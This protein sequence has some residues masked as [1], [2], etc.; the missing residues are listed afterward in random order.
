E[1]EE[2][3]MEFLSFVEEQ[4]LHVWQHGRDLWEK[5]LIAVISVLLT[6]VIARW[7]HRRLRSR[8]LAGDARNVLALEQIILQDGVLLNRSCGQVAL[9]DVFA[10]PAAAVDFLVRAKTTTATQPLVSM[11]G[12]AGSFYLH[13]L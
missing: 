10:N 4:L 8:M 1:S 11:A 9:E 7:R 6:W 13:Q 5:L 12:K 3:G 2:I